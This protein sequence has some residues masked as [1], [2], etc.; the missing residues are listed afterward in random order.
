MSDKLNLNAHDI[1]SAANEGY[2]RNLIAKPSPGVGG[3]C[4]TKDPFIYSSFRNDTLTSKL[5]K[6]GRLVNVEAGKYPIKIIN[7]FLNFIKTFF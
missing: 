7:R 1:I 4:L 3:Y 2:P 5:S 6:H